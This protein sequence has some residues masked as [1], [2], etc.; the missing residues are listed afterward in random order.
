M[1]P[2]SWHDSPFGLEATALEVVTRLGLRDVA[3][4][5]AACSSV[6]AAFRC[7]LHPARNA[8]SE[9]AGGV[10]M[11]LVCCILAAA[12]CS[13][14]VTMES[15]RRSDG[16]TVLTMAATAG[17]P[18]VVR[19]LLHLPG[20]AAL[21]S[22]PDIGGA[23]PMHYAALAG[24]EHVCEVLLAFRACPDVADTTGVR[25][26][27]LAAESGHLASCRSL[28]EGRAD[29]APRDEDAVTPLLLAVEQ[30][31]VDV[32]TLLVRR[33]ADPLASSL[34]GRT[35]MAVARQMGGQ[36]LLGALEGA[37][38]PQARKRLV[39]GPEALEMMRRHLR[40]R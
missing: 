6:A 39:Q 30:K 36:E 17:R 21:V 25:P 31:H 19:W 29:V 12:F 2:A 4:L 38:W 22:Q 20:C 18:D 9:A 37:L 23:C 27:H 14:Q 11:D 1:G 33:R 5:A 28:V 8:A 16:R 15:L 3:A 24:H 13:G 7:A 26:L 34:H 32:C 35:P 40:L 10:V